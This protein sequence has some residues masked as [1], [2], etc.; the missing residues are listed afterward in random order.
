[1]RQPACGW[2][3]LNYPLPR[4]Q[5]NDQT[6]EIETPAADSAEAPADAE[7]VDDTKK[8]KQGPGK[9]PLRPKSSTKDSREAA[10]EVLRSMTR[11]R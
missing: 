8:G 3:K 7:Q 1:M 9:L 4:T 5:S 2:T 11:R 6:S 10:A